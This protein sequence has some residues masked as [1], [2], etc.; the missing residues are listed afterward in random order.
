MFQISPVKLL[1][2]LSLVGKTFVS[3]VPINNLK[4]P[5]KGIVHKKK[6]SSAHFL[7]AAILMEALLTCSNPHNR[8][9]VA[10]RDRISPNPVK[11]AQT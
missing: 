4:I 7:L 5:L 3:F 1:V 11:F 9:G 8:S 2:M 6:R 10:Q